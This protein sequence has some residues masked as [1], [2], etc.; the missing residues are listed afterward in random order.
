MPVPKRYFRKQK[1]AA[2]TTDSNA[3]KKGANLQ[4]SY[5]NPPWCTWENPD[6]TALQINDAYDALLDS[7]MFP[8]LADEVHDVM[9]DACL[10]GSLNVSE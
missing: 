7:L 5:R 2:K 3:T 9:L 1:T 4:Q 8:K 6:A 10:I